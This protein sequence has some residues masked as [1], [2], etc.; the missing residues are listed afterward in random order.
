M[1]AIVIRRAEE[2]FMVWIGW[3]R[4]FLPVVKSTMGKV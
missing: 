3:S 4:K 2:A 1:I